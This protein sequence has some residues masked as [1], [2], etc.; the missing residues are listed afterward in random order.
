MPTWRSQ[1]FKKAAERAGIPSEVTGNAIA[2][3]AAL[4]RQ[5][6]TAPIIFSLRHLSRLSAVSYTYLRSVVERNEP[7]AYR[8][9]RIRKRP[10]PNEKL[11]YRVIA[12]PDPRLK[13]VQ[14]WIDQ[15][16]L[17]HATPDE[18]SVAFTNGASVYEAASMHCGARWLIKLDIRSFF[19][20]ISEQQAYGV[21]YEL[22]YQ[23]LVAFELARLC[24]RMRLK[25]P[26]PERFA[27]PR[28]RFV[29]GAYVSSQ[30]GYL[31]QGAP[32]SP[33]LSNLAVRSLD[34]EIR[35]IAERY[36]LI[37]TRYADDLALSTVSDDFSRRTA[38]SVIG[39]IYRAIAK[40]GLSPNLSKTHIVSPRG[41]KVVLGLLVDGDR[42]RLR[43][44]FKARLRQHL[45]Y[46]TQ[47]DVGPAR[48]AEVNGEATIY[49]LRNHVK[50]LL[51]FAH[52]VEP[53]YAMKQTELFNTIEWP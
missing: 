4:R 7:D 50:G 53:S 22:G 13:Q 32:T 15:K 43:R 17:A 47:S 41:R 39:Q 46:L 29:I 30:Q 19:E 45:Y 10:L 25:L 12:V 5:S 9:F 36:N 1:H 6:Q 34:E 26:P 44:E 16:I 14:Q 23:P 21:F 51:A 8:L 20:S 31:P 2:T 38:S 52:G 49:G 35:S 33:R 27:A 42:P 28:R 18:A 40:F 11:R 48:H 37:F 3:V 24:T